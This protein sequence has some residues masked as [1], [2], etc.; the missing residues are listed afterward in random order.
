MPDPN[1]ILWDTW[2]LKLYTPVALVLLFPTVVT[3][4]PSDHIA[5]FYDL[6]KAEGPDREGTAA[7][8]RRGYSQK[9]QSA[10]QRDSAEK[11]KLCQILIRFCGTRGG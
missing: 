3:S 8:D 7:A 10:L 6:A 5:P 4:R 9:T 1:W 2:R 11:I